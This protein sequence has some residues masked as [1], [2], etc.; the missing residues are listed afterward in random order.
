MKRAIAVAEKILLGL[1]IALL[2][3]MVTPSLAAH[4][5]GCNGDDMKGNDGPQDWYLGAGCDHADVYG[6][7]DYVNG[8]ADSDYLQMG[9]GADKAHGGDNADLLRGGENGIPYR[10]ALLGDQGSDDLVDTGGAADTDYG[11]GGPGLDN[12]NTSD[13][14][15]YDIARG[16]EPADGGIPGTETQTSDFI[17]ADWYDTG[18]GGDDNDYDTDGYCEETPPA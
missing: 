9:P 10:D 8:G 18:Q 2:A 15:G 6:G 3:S 12:V 14:D 17:N 7:D 1:M 11:C 16:E 13:A 5:P 4:A